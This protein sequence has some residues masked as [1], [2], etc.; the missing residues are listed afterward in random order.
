MYLAGPHTPPP[1][2]LR[3]ATISERQKT[4]RNKPNYQEI[5]C[6]V[7]FEAHQIGHELPCSVHDSDIPGI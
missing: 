1:Y 5:I 7:H 3:F 2:I 6:L 4:V